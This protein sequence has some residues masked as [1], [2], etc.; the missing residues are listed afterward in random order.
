MGGGSTER[1]RG[2]LPERFPVRA[3]GAAIPVNPTAL[4]AYPLR[5]KLARRRARADP[6]R[7]GWW[8]ARRVG[9]RQAPA[10]AEVHG[11]ARPPPLI[12][13]RAQGATPPSTTARQ[14]AGA[15]AAELLDIAESPSAL[16]P[17]PHLPPSCFGIRWAARNFFLSLMSQKR[18]LGHGPARRRAH[19]AL[20]L[21]KQ[22]G[23][24]QRVIGSSN[25]LW[26]P[27]FGRN[28]RAV[29]PRPQCLDGGRDDR[30]G[31]RRGG[32][33]R[34]RGRRASHP[35]RAAQRRQGRARPKRLGRGP[36]RGP[37]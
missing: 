37:F 2:A 21:T 18:N 10:G 26:L 9:F 23:A 6:R 33:V 13:I 1:C 16:R 27:G 34:P 36:Q 29:D 7:G 30:A 22:M 11:T 32:P 19:A 8:H 28:A 4:R 14:A 24:S 12:A 17:S 35:G 3:V 20:N 15:R 25:M 5:C 31:D